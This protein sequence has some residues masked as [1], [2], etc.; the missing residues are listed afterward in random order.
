WGGG[1]GWGG[2]GGGAGGRGWAGGFWPR[3][4]CGG[5]WWSAPARRG[6]PAPRHMRSAT[7]HRAAPMRTSQ[8][9]SEYRTFGTCAAPFSIWI[10]RAGIIPRG[11]V[12]GIAELGGHAPCRRRL[13]WRAHMVATSRRGSEFKL[14]GLR[15]TI[16]KESWLCGIRSIIAEVKKFAS[17]FHHANMSFRWQTRQEGVRGPPAP[18]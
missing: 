8:R 3:R 7:S 11:V 15:R 2:G 1:A 5:G 18:H 12:Y 13:V 10:A 16:W 14:P 9:R 6:P 17:A 4:G